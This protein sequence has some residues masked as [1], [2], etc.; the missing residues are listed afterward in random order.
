MQLGSTRWAIIAIA[1]VFCALGLSFSP[2]ALVPHSNGDQLLVTAPGLHFL[3]GRALDRLH[4]GASIP[5]AFQMTLTT[6]PRSIP[7]HRVLSRFVV[8]YDVWGEKYKVVQTSGSRR[9]VTNLAASAAET[10]CIDQMS[11]PTADVP[12][13]KDLWVR[14][15]IRA[16]EPVQSPITETGLSV[17]SL[18]AL[19]STKAPAQ[20][21]EWNAETQPFRLASLRR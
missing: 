13:D 3:T 11:I 16:E 5:F 1:V 14:L 4:N 9:A 10:W 17:T 12:A 20:M 15:E 19:F 6:L 21:Q 18:I 8:S 7:L 2:Q